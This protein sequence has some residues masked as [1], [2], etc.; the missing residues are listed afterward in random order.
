MRLK[1]K[2]LKMDDNHIVITFNLR[3]MQSYQKLLY[4]TSRI[5]KQNLKYT[6]L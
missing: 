3:I 1:F 2:M 4:I 6:N 5:G